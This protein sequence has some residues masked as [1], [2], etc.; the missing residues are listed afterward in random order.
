[1]TARPECVA[2]SG[3]GTRCA[4]DLHHLRR[5]WSAAATAWAGGR[6]SGAP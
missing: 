4:G 5:P 2:L 3:L 6:G 1:M